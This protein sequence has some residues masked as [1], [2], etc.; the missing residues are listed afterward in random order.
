[1]LAEMEDELAEEE[2]LAQEAE[3]RLSIRVCADFL[4]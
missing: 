1:M 2:R 4:D 3:V